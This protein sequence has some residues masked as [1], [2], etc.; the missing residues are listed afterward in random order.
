M[1][2]PTTVTVPD[3]GDFTDVPVIEILVTAG[4]AVEA[5]QPIVVLESDKAT[6]EI[7][8]PAAGTVTAIH[9]SVGDTVSEGSRLLDLEVSESDG[10]DAGDDAG[11]VASESVDDAQNSGDDGDVDVAAQAQPEGEVT[12]V[13]SGD[14]PGEAPDADEHA[15]VLVLGSGPGGY[16]AA[17]RA[18]DLG[19]DV[20][21]VERHS[22]L[23]G[24]CLNV[25]CIPSK[26]LLHV[27]ETI[28][29]ARDGAGHG[30]KFVEPTI[31]V[32]A[33]RDWKDG[34]VGRL[35]GGLAG[36]A[37]RRKV[38]VARGAGRFTGP[39]LLELTGPDGAMRTIS[40]DHAIVAA[41]SE[42]V[43]LPG[44]PHEDARVIDSAGALALPDVPQ[45]LLVV[46]GGIIGLEMAT[47]YVAL[48]SEVTVV[49]LAG[50][51]IPGADRDLVKPLAK[52]LAERGVLVHLETRVDTLEPSDDGLRATFAGEKAPGPATFDRV[53][54]AVGRRA[55]GAALGLDAIEGVTVDDRGVIEVD[56]QMRT[57]ASHVFAIGDIVGAPMLAH[58]ATHEAKVAAE[59]IA[60]HDVTFDARAI[61][62]VAYTD[63]EVAWV[64]LTETEAKEQ[65]V[66]YEKAAFPWAASGRALSMGAESGVTKLLVDPGSRRVL[67]GAA[68]GPH[69]G[70]LVAEIGL[71]IEMGAEAGDLALTVHA[72]PT[73][74]E[75]VG[76]AAEIAEG[77]ITDLPPQRKRG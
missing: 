41:G 65:G 56:E 39:R 12:P 63:P 19:L 68:V 59:V 11:D 49:E 3:I 51:L 47:V 9:V 28:Q 66:E 50:Q 77:T 27:A 46:G 70:E 14:A 22:A 57:G 21:L 64:G 18:A 43:E 44:I 1:S 42:P 24:V 29:N 16:T 7:P 6:V 8:A 72:H 52:R 23:G 35:T 74:S 10:H 67:G 55:N 2:D 76:L 62:S 34:I 53:L 36:M 13:T 37:E 32:D 48:G 45:R 60:G 20:V 40:F 5:E 58:K 38:R 73:L 30:V 4:D 75:T 17:F 54:V 69:A 15:G 61:P 31:D 33:L 71:A 26:A 25:G